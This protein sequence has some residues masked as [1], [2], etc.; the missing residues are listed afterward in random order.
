MKIGFIFLAKE[1]Y[2]LILSLM[3]VPVWGIGPIMEK[4]LT[5]G[6]SSA[7]LIAMWFQGPYLNKY[8][9]RYVFFPQK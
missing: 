2:F 7:F 6:H 3:L 9:R 1:C 5:D 4:E 8:G